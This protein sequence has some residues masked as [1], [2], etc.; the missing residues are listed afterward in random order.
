MEYRHQGIACSLVQFAYCESGVSSLTV[1]CVDCDAEMYKA[2][3]FSIPP[4]NLLAFE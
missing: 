2:L 1:G 4:G 3:G